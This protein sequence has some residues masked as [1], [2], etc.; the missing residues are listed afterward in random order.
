[1]RRTRPLPL[2]LA[3]GLIASVGLAGCASG[4]SGGSTVLRKDIGKVMVAQLTTAREKVFGKHTIPMYREE[5]TSRTLYW[6]TQWLPRGPAPEESAEGVRGG[7][8]R[9]ILRGTYVEERL[10]GTVVLR[11]RFEVENQIQ[12]DLNPE[13]HPGPVPPMVEE[14]FEEVYDDL[15]LELR[16]GV[17]R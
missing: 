3:L 16:A 6:E 5:N 1:M 9:I 8:N 17:I 4:G 14:M 12:T 10:D 13:W 2:L 7:R 15:M 11:V